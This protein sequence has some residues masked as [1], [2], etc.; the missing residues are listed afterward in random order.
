MS[1]LGGDLASAFV[2]SRRRRFKAAFRRQ[3]SVMGAENR[4][5]LL[6]RVELSYN[7]G[8]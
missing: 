5:Y 7:V 4:Q 8:S 1:I 3:L 2:E 6:A